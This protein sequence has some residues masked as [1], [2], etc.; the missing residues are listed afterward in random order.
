[1]SRFHFVPFL[2]CSF[3]AKNKQNRS[4]T[5]VNPHILLCTGC[6]G[7]G[8]CSGTPQGNASGNGQFQK[9]TCICDTGYEGLDCEKEVDGCAAEPCSLGR[10]CS[11]LSIE[12][13]RKEGRAY[14]CGPCPEGFVTDD[15][16][17][18]IDV[19]ECSTDPTICDVTSTCQN[20]VGSFECICNTGYRMDGNSK[21]QC[22]GN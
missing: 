11:N 6:N 15:N 19:D 8:H 22:N 14:K 7:R 12:Q 20:T 18:C 2:F 10:N 21:T 3:V 17:T 1:M 4:S 5:A 16:D 13:Q 9:Y